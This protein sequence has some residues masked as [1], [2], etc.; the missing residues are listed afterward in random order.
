MTPSFEFEVTLHRV[1]DNYQVDLHFDR[2]DS[3]SDV[4]PIRG[5]AKLDVEVLRA[6]SDDR[7][8]YGKVLHK[9]LFSDAKIRDRFMMGCGLADGSEAPIR[10]RL[11]IASDASELHALCWEALRDP[12]SSELLVTRERFLFSR[13]ISNDDFRPVR[14]RAKGDLR[15]LVVIANPSN[16]SDYKPNGRP[17]PPLDVAGETT[18]ARAGLGTLPIT[19]LSTP[20]SASFNGIVSKLREGYDILYVICHGAL[21]DNEPR[22]C[23]EDE[24]GKAAIVLGSELVTRLSEL[25]QR[26]RLVV[27][28]SCQSAGTGAE[29]RTSDEGLL[30][31]LGPRL[32][33]A[34]IP[35]VIAMQGNVTMRTVGT[36]MPVF[37][38]ELQVDG[39]ID[40][41][42]AAARGAV[43][44]Q[45]DWWM[46]VL[47]MSLKQGRIRWYTPG[48]T[49]AEPDFERWRSLINN[50]RKRSC[51]PII[52]SGVLESL[53]GSFRDIARD[54]A[55]TH[56][57]PMAGNERE[58]LPLVAQYLVVSQGESTY[59]RDEFRKALKGGTLRNYGHDLTSDERQGS[60]QEVI[61][62][63]G[64]VRRKLEGAEPHKVLAALDLP[65]YLT[66]NP[67]NLL[68]DALFEAGK[69]PHVLLCPRGYDANIPSEEDQNYR[70]T[71]D[72]PLV[73]H[74]FGHLRE[75]DSVVLT[76]DDYF[77]YL[78]D[79]TRTNDI[80][81][82]IV[83]SS[84]AN[85]AL[86][87][88]GF[89]MSDWDFR[90]F[91]RS[92]MSQEGRDRRK[93]FS[94]VA[95]QID[96]EQERLVDPARARRYLE[97]YFLDT[98]ISIFWGSAEDFLSQLQRQM[99]NIPC[100]NPD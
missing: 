43:R 98:Q 14:F 32:A 15:A 13:F 77:D 91:F 21:I 81:P 10:L 61:S 29:A 48:F 100:P 97:T 88:L 42:M 53:V 47:F 82:K 65:V 59:A 7:V 70:A 41:A 9:S 35:A 69:K 1:D 55:T 63:A 36:F 79:V 50:I 67:D 57:Y 99:Q 33:A 60:V 16:I 78:I 27:L 23:L 76:Q 80:I 83:R 37:F 72:E 22:L 25:K 44:D 92:I 3:E 20:G 51:T 68:A 56:Q 2:S 54:W 8:E 28:A 89:Q 40:R 18:R 45:E 30:A 31:A 73:Y 84:L 75:P 38:R 86:L 24:T 39:Q 19:I 26:P 52:G 4:A 62:S 6:L 17:L 66:T 11:Y 12:E 95:V 5:E 49:G 46:P 58:Q 74:L 71:K 87:F 93:R 34:G 94:H 64:A 96:P 90:V 85:T